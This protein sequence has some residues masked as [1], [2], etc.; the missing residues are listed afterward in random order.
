M[1]FS[2]Q[3]YWSGF[4]CPPP[5][6]LHDPGI[7]A[8]NLVSA[9]LPRRFFTTSTT[10]EAQYFVYSTFILQSIE[11]DRMYHAHRS[12]DELCNVSFLKKV[13]QLLNI[14]VEILSYSH[15]TF[16]IVLHNYRMNKMFIHLF[17]AFL[18]ITK[19]NCS[20][21]CALYLLKNIC[22]ISVYHYIKRWIGLRALWCRCLPLLYY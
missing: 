20:Q 17:S 21:I 6:D 1:G 9:A 5:G 12:F 18:S 13:L 3:K 22:I 15:S 2:R 7:E 11:S 14:K 16:W 19:L 8:M 4:L 10:W